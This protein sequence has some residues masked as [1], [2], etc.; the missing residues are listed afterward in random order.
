MEM[1]LPEFRGDHP[2]EVLLNLYRDL[3]WDGETNIDPMSIVLSKNDWLRLFDKIRSTVPE[4]Q[5]INA[6]FLLINKGP[7]VSSIIPEG[8]VLIRRR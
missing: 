5:V 4:E 6:G 1:E 3:G 2:A 7:S 8:K